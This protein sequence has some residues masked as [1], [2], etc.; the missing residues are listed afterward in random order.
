MFHSDPTG[1]PGYAA[2]LLGMVAFL[3]ALFAARQR[4]G[5]AD[6]GPQ[7]RSLRSIFGIMVQSVAFFLVSF[8][9]ARITLDPLSL[10]ALG[11]AAIVGLLMIAVVWLFIWASQTMGKNWSVVARTRSDHELVTAGPFA[12]IRHP[13]YTALGLF[14]IALAVTTGN[15][16]RLLLGLPICA[17]GTW[18]RIA[19][20]ERLLGAMFGPDY[21]AYAARV[22]R[23]VPGVF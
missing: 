6:T 20:E 15:V 1:L 7:K 11:E 12:Y 8:G 23:F 22:K 16:E 17:L 21:D 14:L 10:P 4:R 3:I 19:E 9:V 13:I 2:F 18:L 5:A